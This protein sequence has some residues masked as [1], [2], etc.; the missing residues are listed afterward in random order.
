MVKIGV[1][2]LTL[3]LS[4]APAFAKINMF[5][6]PRYI[7]PLSFYDDGGRAYKLTEFKSDLLM[8]VVWARSCGPC[9][10]DLKHLGRFV[11]KT[12]GKG[13]EVILISPDKDWKTVA[14]K[15]MFLKRLGAENMVSF[16]DKNS[17][18]RDG[19]GVAVTPTA[20]LV[21]KNGEEVGQITGSIEW[22][23]Q[24]I[25]DYMLKLKSEVSQKLN[26]GESA[27]K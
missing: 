27:D 17:R 11:R 25:V 20:I 21:N 12:M 5:P 22:E 14:E 1:V 9:I 8:A 10:K 13:I 23:D 7:P 3:F 4:A 2:L 19:M 24:E 16:N 15:R 6:K 18:F 26:D